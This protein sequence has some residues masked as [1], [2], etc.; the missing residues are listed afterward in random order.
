V[1]PSRVSFAD[2]PN[3]VDSWQSSEAPISA[4][5]LDVLKP[6]DY[7]SRNFVNPANADALNLWIAYYATQGIGE[8]IHSP[9][10]CIPGG[11]WK[12][13]RIEP[14]ILSSKASSTVI[15]ANR[16]VIER[17]GERQLVYYWFQG[18]GR[19]EASEYAVKLHLMHDAL[20]RHRT[21]GALV[22]VVIPLSEAAGIEASESKARAFIAQLQPKLVSYLPD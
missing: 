7:L 18:R 21:D 16:A 2:F 1:A 17:Q 13:E 6:T 4:E 14:V 19:Y 12:I 5:A 22:R 15:H 10:I 9:R 11:G 8:T 20:V 3:A